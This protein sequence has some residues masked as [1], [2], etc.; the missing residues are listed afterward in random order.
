MWIHIR[1]FLKGSG[2]LFLVMKIDTVDSGSCISS[3]YERSNLTRVTRDTKS[4]GFERQT[5]CEVRV[6]MEVRKR[7][8]QGKQIIFKRKK[9]W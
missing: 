1:K 3:M 8:L 5:G 4:V 7:L 2:I 9:E 6:N